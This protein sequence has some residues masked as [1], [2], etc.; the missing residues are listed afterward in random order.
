MQLFRALAAKGGFGRSSPTPALGKEITSVTEV[1]S[2]VIGG[3]A[4]RHKVY[5]RG[6]PR[7]EQPP[8][9]RGTYQ[10]FELPR[11]LGDRS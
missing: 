5:S 2:G 8:R 9:R 6:R 11:R 1:E 3:S 4:E 10:T 7:L